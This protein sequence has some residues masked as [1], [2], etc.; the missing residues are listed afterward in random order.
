MRIKTSEKYSAVVVDLKGNVVGGPDSEEFSQLLHSFLDEGKKNVV[1][2]LGSVKFMNSSGLGMLIS[3]FTTMKNGGGSL[4]LANATE[5]INSL[6]VITKL[7]TIFENFN[8]VEE[9]VK[10][11]D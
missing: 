10:S 7:I 2:D 6:L 4:K 5:K 3:G 1:V 8:S 9:A 11:F